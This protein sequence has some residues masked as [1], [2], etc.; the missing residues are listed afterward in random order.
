ML[1]E[2]PN[3][4][5][6]R[7]SYGCCWWMCYIHVSLDQG[8]WDPDTC[9]RSQVP[10]PRSRVPNETLITPNCNNS[11]ATMKFGNMMFISGTVKPQL[12]TY[13]YRSCISTTEGSLAPIN[14]MAMTTTCVKRL[15][16]EILMLE[17]NP[18]E[19]ITLIPSADNMRIWSAMIR[20]PPDSVYEG[21]IFDLAIEV[22]AD[23][24]LTPPKMRFLTRIFHPNVHFQ[25][26]NCRYSIPGY[27]L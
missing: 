9:P 6:T 14:T 1:T 5:E 17:K 15:R 19:F 23:H 7:G 24:P 12:N 3:F 25:V 21:F 16:K 11:E 26:R 27:S 4:E 13:F 2:A 18:D 22:G 20:A 10:G 8:I